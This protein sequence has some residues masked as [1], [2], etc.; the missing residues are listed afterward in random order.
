[1]PVI[2][3]KTRR[4]EPRIGSPQHVP[5]RSGA[6][7]ARWQAGD[8]SRVREWRSLFL[9]RLGWLLASLVAA[10]SLPGCRSMDSREIDGVPLGAMTAPQILEI[11][12]ATLARG[13]AEDAAE[14]AMYVARRFPD[15][16][17][18]EE[19]RV[20]AG[21]AF[22]AR[23]EWVAAFR[24]YRFLL[25]ASPRSEYRLKLEPVIF[26]LALALL[27]E[28]PGWFSDR[29]YAVEVLTYFTIQY[30]KSDN[31]DDAYRLL[32]AYHYEREEYDL[33]LDAYRELYLKYPQSEW[34][35][36][37]EVRVGLCYAR[38]TQGAA[39]DRGILLRARAVLQQYLAKH[40]DGG[41]RDEAAS[42]LQGIEEL[43]AAHEVE[44]A[45]LYLVRDQEIGARLHLANAVLAFPRTLSGE[46][47]RRSLDERGWDLSLHSLDTLTVEGGTY[48]DPFDEQWVGPLGSFRFLRDKKESGP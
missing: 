26:S 42:E 6:A 31:A 47:A 8:R 43:L 23:E 28:E 20:I 30:S 46:E 22:Q 32:G 1:M 44:I 35:E 14:L 2:T 29:S 9:S 11:A 33:A 21:E 25:D 19:A 41:F 48:G 37:A 3:G 7:A 16:L 15:S 13:D 24:Q 12:R 38:L 36:L 17:E 5:L 34:R 45:R 4:V 39:Y 10:V 18:M 40:P 27:R